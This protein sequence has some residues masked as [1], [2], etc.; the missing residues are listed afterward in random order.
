M[1][2]GGL[3]FYF[4]KAN[5]VSFVYVLILTFLKINPLK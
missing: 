4:E 3:G 2:S 1:L 5:L